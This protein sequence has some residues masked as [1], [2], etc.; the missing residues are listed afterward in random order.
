[1]DLYFS[2]SKPPPLTLLLVCLALPVSG[3]RLRMV[4]FHDPTV[5]AIDNGAYV[6]DLHPEFYSIIIGFFLKVAT[7][8]LWHVTNGLFLWV[9][10]A[11]IFFF[12]R[13]SLTRGVH[14]QLGILHDSRL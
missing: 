5:V 9:C 8:K 11:P 1:M 6:L 7:S 10:L 3:I 2:K 13:I 14:F 4:N 12:Y